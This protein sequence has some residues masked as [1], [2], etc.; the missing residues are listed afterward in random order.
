MRVLLI[1]AAL[2]TSASATAKDSSLAVMTYEGCKLALE[3]KPVLSSSES[4]KIGLCHG[5]AKAVEDLSIAIGSNAS[6][7]LPPNADRGQVI[8]QW[9]KWL[10]SDQADFEQMVKFNSPAVSLYG[11]MSKLYPCKKS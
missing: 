4:L 8:A 2:L 7:C 9:V 5:M 1:A 3:D 6:S 10:D 11:N